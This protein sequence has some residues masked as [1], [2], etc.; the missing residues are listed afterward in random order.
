MSQ[1]QQQPAAAALNGVSHPGKVLTL[2]TMNPNVKR[3]EYAV[4]GAIVQRA[5]QLEKELRE[6]GRARERESERARAHAPVIPSPAEDSG[7]GGVR[8]GRPQLVIRK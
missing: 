6:V 7:E 4:R 5:V 8:C 1:Q 2:D 3:V